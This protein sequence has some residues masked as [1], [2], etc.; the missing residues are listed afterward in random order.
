MKRFLFTLLGV[1]LVLLGV[2]AAYNYR[3]D[4]LGI[5]NTD[6]SVRRY[7]VAQ[8]FVKMRYLRDNPQ[9]YNAFCFGSSR[10]SQIPVSELDGN[11]WYNFTY[12]AGLPHEWLEDIRTLIENGTDVRQILIGIDDFS[13]RA[14]PK[15]NETGSGSVFAYRPHDV[16]RYLRALFHRPD[17]QLPADFIEREAILFDIYGGGQTL[18]PWVDEKI[19]ADPQKHLEDPAFQKMAVVHGRRIDATLD[20]LREIVNLAHAHNIELTIIINPLYAWTYLTNDQQDFDEFKRRLAAITDYYDFSGVSEETLDKM[21][22][23][24]T[25]HY[26]QVMG[27]RIL[28]RVYG[29]ASE[30]TQGF[31]RLVTAENVDAHLAELAAV[32]AQFLA[33]HPGELE[34]LLFANSFA[35]YLP[36]GFQGEPDGRLGVHLD[37]L[38]VGDRAPAAETEWPQAE[39][40]SM[41]GWQTSS[42]D[43]AAICRNE[44]TGAVYAMHVAA[45]ENRGV[46]ATLA[47][48]AEERIGFELHAVD[49]TL[50][51]G[52]WALELRT[53]TPDGRLLASGIL[54]HITVP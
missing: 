10:V 12:G 2:L 54:A 45:T 20:E 13:F 53:R 21:N 25:S 41:T 29:G 39:K 27:R 23:Y 14:D 34:P 32:R 3:H 44:E 30:G 16:E 49:G 37:R 36:A 1:M 9:K 17:P 6:F 38:G 18:Y 51:T 35:P 5:I 33:D 50:P 42:G 48:P 19:E 46:S 15:A 8:R 11:R 52:R 43:T 28:A 47:L 40:F 31:G 4:A 22:Y 7:G 26:R 24:E